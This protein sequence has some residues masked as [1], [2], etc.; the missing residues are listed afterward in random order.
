V[1][2][3]LTDLR[4][5]RNELAGDT[6]TNT[7]RKIRDSAAKFYFGA[8]AVLAGAIVTIGGAI[9]IEASPQPVQVSED[10]AITVYK[11]RYCGCCHEWIEHLRA[12]GLSVAVKNVDSTQPVRSELG[13]PDSMASCHTAV[14]GDYWIEG[15]VPA[16]LVQQL[17]AERPDDIEGI[18]VPGMPA[19]SPGMEGPNAVTYDVIAHASDGTSSVYATR[20]GKITPDRHSYD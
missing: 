1:I 5:I 15:H 2:E 12:S 14:A 8:L 18:A 19:G 13:V 7:V 4:N 16:D 20:Q 10:A 6:Q 11:N 17:L 3:E 9:W